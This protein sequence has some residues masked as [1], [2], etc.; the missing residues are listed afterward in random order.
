MPTNIK[1][2]YFN[3]YELAEKNQSGDWKKYRFLKIFPQYFTTSH[4]IFR[5]MKRLKL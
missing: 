5:T 2:Y 3:L 1:N 4:R